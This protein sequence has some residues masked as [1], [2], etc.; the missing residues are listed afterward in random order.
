MDHSDPLD[1]NLTIAKPPLLPDLFNEDFHAPDLP[2]IILRQV[3]GWLVVRPSTLKAFTRYGQRKIE[4][5]LPMLVKRGLL[6]PLGRLQNGRYHDMGEE[7]YTIG[8]EAPDRTVYTFKPRLRYESIKRGILNQPGGLISTRGLVIPMHQF[9]VAEVAAWLAE[10]LAELQS[11]HLLVPEQVLRGE[12]GWYSEKSHKQ[13]AAFFCTPVP[14]AWLIFV[15]Y[16][17]RIEV[18]ISEVSTAKV[19]GICAA[20]PLKEPVLYVVLEEGLYR[21]LIPLQNE[22]PHLFVV[23]FRN[24]DDLSK[25]WQWHQSLAKR[26]G[27]KLWWLRDHYAGL[28]FAMATM[29]AQAAK[30]FSKTYT[31]TTAQLGKIKFPS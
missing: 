27:Y 19:R 31:A 21:R 2:E 6:K 3:Y 26:G 24:K 11:P 12:Y 29:K 25:F 22:I 17:L 28:N 16:S 1:R 18:Q 30:T 5:T 9:Y 7:L 13:K 10:E 20:S 15:C 4:A 8:T 23:R 14:D